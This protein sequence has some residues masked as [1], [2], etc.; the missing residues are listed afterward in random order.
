MSGWWQIALVVLVEALAL[1]FLVSRFW[2]RGRR[3]RVLTKP[4]VRASDLVRKKPHDCH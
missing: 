3:P 4:D 1:A 2:L